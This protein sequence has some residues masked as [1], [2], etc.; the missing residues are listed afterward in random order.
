MIGH[1]ILRSKIESWPTINN[2]TMETASPDTAPC[3][4]KA[5]GP[6]V[7]CTMSKEFAEE[8]GYHDALCWTIGAMLLKV[9]EQ[10]F[11]Y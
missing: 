1:H 3:E 10:I 11:F 9:L 6:Y 2:F 7:I 8:K 5:S 4:A